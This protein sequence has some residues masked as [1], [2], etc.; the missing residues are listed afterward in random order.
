MHIRKQLSIFLAFFV[1]LGLWVLYGWNYWNGDR[2]IYE[3]YYSRETV[4]GWGGELGYGYL[5]LWAHQAG[6]SFQSFQ[7]FTSFVTLLLLFRYVVKRTLS[8]LLSLF[9]YAF[10][11]FALD[12]VLVRN[13]LAFTILLQAF[14]VL[15]E[16]KPFSRLKY[17]L[18]LALA[19]TVHQSSFVFIVFMIMPMNRVFPLSRFFAIWICFLATYFVLRATVPLPESLAS[20]FDYY[21]ASLKSSLFNAAVHIS[22][23]LAMIV[24]VIFERKSVFRVSSGGERDRELFFV[25]N[26]NLLSLFFIVLYFESEIFIRLL[27][28]ILFLNIMHCVSSLFLRRQTSLFLFLYIFFFGAY[29]VLFFLLPVADLSVIPLFQNNLL[30]G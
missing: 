16:G 1:F 28:T 11:F 25:L 21:G 13:F 24:V 30:L 19:T 8:P 9:I 10:C 14:I 6:F 20:H 12:Y 26:I 23:V 4:E 3:L 2:E 15:F 27:R 5:N 7:I 22:S 17:A 18:L 29:L